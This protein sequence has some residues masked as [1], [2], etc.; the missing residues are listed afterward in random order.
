MKEEDVSP[1]EERKK[2]FHKL[3]ILTAEANGLTLSEMISP[4]ERITGE[5]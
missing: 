3:W 5:N 1:S 2:P 4:R